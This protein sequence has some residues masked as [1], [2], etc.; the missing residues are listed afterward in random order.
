MFFKLVFEICN[1]Y[2]ESKLMKS[3]IL[4]R[5]NL[6]ENI[7]SHTK[8]ITFSVFKKLN[9]NNKIFHKKYKIRLRI[10]SVNYKIKI[11]AIV[12]HLQRY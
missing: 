10:N 4:R 7:F 1:I 3:S 5:K 9:N 12:I 6:L 11:Y 8:R 2:S